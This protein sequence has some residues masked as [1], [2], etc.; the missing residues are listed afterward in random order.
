M[1]LNPQS[2]SRGPSEVAIRDHMPGPSRPSLG[3]QGSTVRC[4][5]S[6]S[7][8]WRSSCKYGFSLVL[9][10]RPPPRTLLSSRADVPKHPG[11]YEHEPV[12][13]AAGHLPQMS[14]TQA[15]RHQ[16]A[17]TNQSRDW[18][19]VGVTSTDPPPERASSPLL[20]SSGSRTSKKHPQQKKIQKQKAG[21]A[22][23][24]KSRPRIPM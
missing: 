10:S 1:E 15:P 21:L 14:M 3:L 2:P 18:W 6:V 17:D 13:H 22:V 23:P 24:Q 19:Q 5:S 4:T 7:C 20:F 16:G 12:R 8:S 9:G 11:P